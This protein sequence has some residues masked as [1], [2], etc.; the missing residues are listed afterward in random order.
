MRPTYAI[1]TLAALLASNQGLSAP[2]SNPAIEA[3]LKTEVDAQENV[4]LQAIIEADLEAGFPGKEKVVLWT[5]LGPTYWSGKLSV[6]SGQTGQWS[7]IVTLDMGG[8]EPKSGSLTVS[9]DGV[10]SLDAKTPG[11][12][13]PICCPSQQKNLKYR[14]GHGQLTEVK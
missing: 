9:P 1:L 3:A 6:M 13:D 5:L 2:L 4:D 11:P 8:V 12:D 7:A 10:I 14:Y